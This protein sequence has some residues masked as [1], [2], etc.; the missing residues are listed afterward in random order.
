MEGNQTLNVKEKMEPWMRQR[1]Y[2][3]IQVNKSEALGSMLELEAES[4][5]SPQEDPTAPGVFK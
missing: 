5:V 4:F 1:G 3:I 2:P